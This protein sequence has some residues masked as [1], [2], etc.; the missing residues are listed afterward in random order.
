MSSFGPKDRPPLQPAPLIAALDAYAVRWVM[1]G[2]AVLSLHGADIIPN[3]LDVVPDLSEDN[4][5]R[6]ADCLKHLNA[7]AAY[8]DGWGGARGTLEACANWRPD[9]PDADNLDWLFVTAFGPLDIVIAHADPYA[10]LMQGAAQHVAE[11]VSYWVCDPR[12]VLKA[13]EPRNRTKDKARAAI[14]QQ[15]RQRFGMPPID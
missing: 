2:S 7:V 8:L 4:L 1:C 3:D 13:L 6:L 10:S 15:M 14:Y 12:R 11:G 5:R 9:P